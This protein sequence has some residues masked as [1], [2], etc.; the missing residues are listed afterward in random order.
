MYA[1]AWLDCFELSFQMYWE[2]LFN[3]SQNSLPFWT[4]KRTTSCSSF[5]ATGFVVRLRDSAIY[6]RTGNF[7]EQKSGAIGLS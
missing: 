2:N 4:I 7:R 1:T 3:V 5:N 6:F